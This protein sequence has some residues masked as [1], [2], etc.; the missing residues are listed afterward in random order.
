MEIAALSVMVRNAGARMPPC[1]VPRMGIPCAYC[2]F[3]PATPYLNRLAIADQPAALFG[4]VP[5]THAPLS[6]IVV[7]AVTVPPEITPLVV[8]WPDMVG[9]AH[10]LK[11]LL[12]VVAP[13][14]PCAVMQSPRPAMSNAP[15]GNT[16]PA[17]MSF[18]VSA[19]AMMLLSSQ[20]YLEPSWLT[21]T[22]PEF[23]SK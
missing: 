7:P 12:L 14:T 10:S 8:V 23:C 1:R 20:V 17:R 13:V 16:M 19:P 4:V 21:T 3:D 15:A 6:Q 22:T 5:L 2:V 18:V 9:F 11:R